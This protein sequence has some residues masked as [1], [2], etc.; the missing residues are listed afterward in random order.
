M[1][2]TNA[3]I[4]PSCKEVLSGELTD[5][6]F[7][8]L[9][10]MLSELSRNP[11]N[12][13]IDFI[14][15][16]SNEYVNC[17]FEFDGRFANILLPN[18]KNECVWNLCFSNSKVYISTYSSSMSIMEEVK[19]KSYAIFRKSKKF[20][21]SEDFVPY[22]SIRAL[23]EKSSLSLRK[24]MLRR[25]TR[26]EKYNDMWALQSLWNWFNKQPF[27]LTFEFQYNSCMHKVPVRVRVKSYVDMI[28]KCQK[29]LENN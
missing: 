16:G 22:D 4:S 25:I 20:Q 24:K 10:N 13:I 18:T 15:N 29:K 26:Y 28:V 2:T 19:T 17:N 12:Y 1:K 8:S 9:S 6:L 23:I 21:F 11:T 27:Q 5:R 3:I 14:P 7:T